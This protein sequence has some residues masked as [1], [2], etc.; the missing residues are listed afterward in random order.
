MLVLCQ[1]ST[2]R[3]GQAGG[4]GGFGMRT[5]F[6]LEM[7][8]VLNKIELQRLLLQFYL[9]ATHIKTFMLHMTEMQISAICWENCT[10]VPLQRYQE[11]QE[12][13]LRTLIS[14]NS[15]EVVGGQTMHHFILP[16]TYTI[17][18]GVFLQVFFRKDTPNMVLAY[19]PS[20]V[21]HRNSQGGTAVRQQC[22]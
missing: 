10:T 21:Y 5:D 14:Y 16:W 17:I 8:R 12:A 4:G 1:E 11:W 6:L 19:A 15:V 22:W 18:V 20:C 13:G 3:T 2:T 9:I 7:N